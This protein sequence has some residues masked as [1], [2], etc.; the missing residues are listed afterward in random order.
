MKMKTV[1]RYSL[2]VICCMLFTVHCS[3]FTAVYA[4][5]PSQQKI[6]FNFVEVEIP[7]VIKFISD[8]TDKNFIFD[9]RVK[10]KVTI[11]APTRLTV[12]ESFMLFTSILELKGFTVV[13]SGTKAYKIIPVSAA[14][15]SGG[16]YKDEKTPVN[17]SYITR[18][19]PVE[20]IKAEDAVRFIQ[21]M[22]SRDGHISSFG[23]GNYILIVD[24]ALNIEKILSILK[25]IDQPQVK[26]KS[27]KINV[28]SLENAD[29]TELS[30]VLEGILK[31][32][33][34][35]KGGTALFEAMGG[36][37]ITADKATNSLIIVASQNDYQNISEVIKSLDKRRRQVFVEAMI[38]EASIDKLKELGTRWRAAARH[39]GEPVAIGGVGNMD[40]TA[41]MSVLN[42]LTGFT[43]GGIGNFLNVP[44]TTISSAGTATTS[45][46]SVPGFAALFSLSDFKDAVNVLSTPQILTSDNEEA[47][48][49]V[50]ENVP[51]ISKRER[52]ITTTNTVLSSIDRKDVGITLK[53]TPQ[54]TEGDYVK[55]NMYQ[56][57]SS[58]KEGTESIVTTVGPTT[59]KRST[60]TAVVVKDAQTVV[61][62]GLIQ[63]KDE[64][65]VAKTPLLGDIPLL[66]WLFKY[67]T[68][69]KKKT[70][71]LVFLTPHIVKESEQLSKITK[72]KH[73]AFAMDEK[74][75]IEG[76]L[77]VKFKDGVTEER[78]KE[79]IAQK[80]AS[81][82]KFI[83]NIKVYHLK[84]RPEQTV[85]YKKPEDS[86]STYCISPPCVVEWQEVMPGQGVEDAITEFSSMPEVQY[87]EPNYKVRIQGDMPFPEAP[88][89]SPE[90]SSNSDKPRMYGGPLHQSLSGLDRR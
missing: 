32:A 26:E 78:I 12:E 64:E 4:E 87:A 33:Q 7:A 79:I 43:M 10:G 59:T 77:L 42:G 45:T 49:V 44:I 90:K 28:Y 48:I 86:A 31:S 9:E 74:L 52:D 8:I 35:S 39:N 89:P 17:E 13:P 88:K 75:Y 46:L 30:K 6:T 73:K 80:G 51:F 54:I 58:V 38:I 24:S 18:L 62:G 57:I 55:L 71:L 14:K 69:A 63:E 1:N 16:L 53:I 60:K 29:A 3:L 84:L 19:L 56:E 85:V 5:S 61:I 27:V 22:V 36:I 34:S 81:V 23:P 41:L 70:N 37:S 40:S 21:P 20:Y 15:Q 65:T 2:F 66:G 50:G 72:E 11:I 67:K 25:N 76:E 83:S 82:I 68:M 47:E